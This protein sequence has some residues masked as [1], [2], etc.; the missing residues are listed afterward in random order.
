MRK[1]TSSTRS[2]ISHFAAGDVLSP[3]LYLE[4]RNEIWVSKEGQ[5]IRSLAKEI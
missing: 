3:I 1:F 4:K 2:S 5:K